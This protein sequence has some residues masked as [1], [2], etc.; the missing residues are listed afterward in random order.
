MATFLHTADWQIGRQYGQF[1]DEDAVLLAK[2]R[3]DAVSAIARLAAE[4]QVDAV[5][6]AGDVFDTQGVSDRSVRRLFAALAPYAG[7]WIMIAGNHDAALADSVWTRARALG[8][9]PD[10]VHVPESTC[11]VALD[12]SRIAVLAA[13]LT[14]RQT[15]DDVTLAFDSMQSPEGWLRVGLAH[16]SIEGHLPDSVDATNPIAADRVKRAALDYLALGDWHGMLSIEPRLW[17]SGTPEPD[18]FRSATAGHVLHV[19]IDAAGGLPEVTPIKLGRYVW[20]QRNAVLALDSDADMLAA[21]LD[22]LGQHDVL[23]LVLTGE[24]SV[25][26]WAA[27]EATIDRCAARIH[28]LRL[29]TAG[30]AVVPDDDDLAALAADGYVG[31]VAAELNALR[32]DATLG[33]T[34]RAALRIL[35]Q[36]QRTLATGSG[37]AS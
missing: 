34:A 12:A 27:L 23:R 30:L 20:Q 37:R 29:D 13:P 10:N 9:V 19:C 5:L 18:R 24:I 3:V 4:R 33:T 1:D 22:A 15:H 36:T 28:A 6:V 21:E 35:L 26:G 25:T 17:Y 7:P 14:Q 31:Q 11:V 2:A 32:D 16:G 8:C